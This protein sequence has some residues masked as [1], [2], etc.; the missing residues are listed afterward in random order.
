M[1]GPETEITP[2]MANAGAWALRLAGL[3]LLEAEDWEVLAAAREIYLA[4][5]SAVTRDHPKSPE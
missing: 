2:E 4:M 1:T 5:E 3:G